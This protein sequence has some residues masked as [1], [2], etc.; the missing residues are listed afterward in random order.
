VSSRRTLI[1]VGAILIGVIAAL[2]IYNYVQGI[3]NRANNNAKLVDVFVAKSD[4]ARGTEGKQASDSGQ[5]GSAQIPQQF[6]PATAITTTDQLAKKVALFDVPKGMV[7]V[8]GMFVDPASAQIS[9]RQRISQP[10]WVA[11]TIS[12]DTV[13]GVGGFLVPGDEVNMTV[14]E[15]PIN[16]PGNAPG[17]KPGSLPHYLFQKVFILAV[18]SQPQLQAGET[19]TTTSSSNAAGNLTLEVPADAAQY[20]IAAQETGTIYLSLV[21]KDY[22]PSVIPPLP[23]NGLI[24]P[25]PGED[26]ARLTPYGPSGNSGPK[27]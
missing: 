14:D 26:P 2:L 10:N 9:F 15:Q 19:A 5:I 18:G 22:T 4:I 11:V 17:W 24:T 20:I 12:T 7:I 16:P 1:L 21:T 25:L 13:R 6:R 3:N 8:N 23:T 27:S